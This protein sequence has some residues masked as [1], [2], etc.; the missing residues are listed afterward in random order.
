MGAAQCT[1]GRLSAHADHA[2]CTW[3]ALYARA[4]AQYIC[5]R[6]TAHAARAVCTQTTHARAGSQLRMRRRLI[7]RGRVSAHAGRWWARRPEGREFYCSLLVGVIPPT[8]VG[9][10]MFFCWLVTWR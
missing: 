10:G 5:G 8:A 4:P 9:G 7:A 2:V 6:C 3:E 1:R